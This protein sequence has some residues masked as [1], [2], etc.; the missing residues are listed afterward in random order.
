MHTSTVVA[1]VAYPVSVLTC[2]ALQGPGVELNG[3]VGVVAA[4]LSLAVQVAALWTQIQSMQGAERA[5]LH[6]E[7]LS[8]KRQAPDGH[9]GG[10][11]FTAREK[12]NKRTRVVKYECGT[13]SLIGIEGVASFGT[14]G[15]VVHTTPTDSSRF[16]IKTN[17]QRQKHQNKA[18]PHLTYPRTPLHTTDMLI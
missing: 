6:A 18:C 5:D 16:T 10:Q 12:K 7:A 2:V 9:R 1:M 14:D 11:R 8:L 15:L 17:L 13:H 3:R 4:V